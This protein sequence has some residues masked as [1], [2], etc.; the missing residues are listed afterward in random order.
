MKRP[1]PM[2]SELM[3]SP[4]STTTPTQN[5]IPTRSASADI[6]LSEADADAIQA[7][8]AAVFL[9]ARAQTRSPAATNQSGGIVR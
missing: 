8:A 4:D 2:R 1:R 3:D 9:A 5:L 7:V 6:V